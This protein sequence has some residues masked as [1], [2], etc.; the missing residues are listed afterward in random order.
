MREMSGVKE[1]KLPKFTK[2]T[3]WNIY[4]IKLESVARTRGRM[5]E[6]IRGDF[7]TEMPGLIEVDGRM[8]LPEL[9]PEQLEMKKEND[10][11]FNELIM[12]MP[13][14]RLTKLVNGAKSEA[15]PEGCVHTAVMLLKAR[16]NKTS[17]GNKRTLKSNFENDFKFPKGASPSKHIDTLMDIKEELKETCQCV[18]TDEDIVDQLIKVLGNDYAFTK[19][20]VKSDR[21]K[22][23]TID[24]HELQE[25][26]KEVCEDIKMEKKKTKK[27][28]DLSDDSSEEEEDDDD[29]DEKGETA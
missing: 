5:F 2:G 10:R 1:H 9:I 3:P 21:R 29:N 24:L 27:N 26:L 19:E 22:G 12:A 6:A 8:V 20:R 4:E 25:E 28:I 11:A 7:M 14:A 17:A 16:I 18:K 23:I 13:N 15:F